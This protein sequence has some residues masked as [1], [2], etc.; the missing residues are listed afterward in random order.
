MLV[1]QAP[2][3]SWSQVYYYTVLIV[4]HTKINDHKGRPKEHRHNTLRGMPA[5]VNR[6]ATTVAPFHHDQENQHRI[7]L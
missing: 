5:V 3:A 4:G 1:M 6:P 2:Q 7:I